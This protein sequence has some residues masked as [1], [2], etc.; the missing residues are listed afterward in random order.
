MVT[1]TR[2]SHETAVSVPADSINWTQ[3]AWGHI[4]EGRELVRRCGRLGGVH[5]AGAES[6]YDQDTLY[7]EMISPENKDKIGK[8]SLKRSTL[9][10]VA[11]FVI[12]L[13]HEQLLIS[14]CSF[15]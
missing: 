3:C 1:C 2:S 15:V 4:K 12:C 10:P 5:R 7:M 9:Y 6:G 11:W 14:I 13:R 8:E